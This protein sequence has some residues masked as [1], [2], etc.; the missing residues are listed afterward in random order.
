LT[1]SLALLIALAAHPSPS[2]PLPGG[3]ASPGDGPAATASGSPVSSPA[4]RLAEILA[5]GDEAAIPELLSLVRT[6]DE[7]FQ[8]NVVMGLVQHFPRQ[9]LGVLEALSQDGDAGVRASAAHGLGHVT[10]GD[11]VPALVRALR[12]PERRV[13]RGA[14]YSLTRPA[15]EGSLSALKIAGGAE[16]SPGPETMS[17]LARNRSAVLAEVLSATPPPGEEA[18]RAIADLADE[19]AA[20]ALVGHFARNLPAAERRLGA[21]LPRLQAANRVWLGR[22]V[23]PPLREATLTLVVDNVFTGAARSRPL[24]L[25][26]VAMQLARRRGEHLERGSALPLPLDGL[27]VVPQ[28]GSPRAESAKS[29][30]TLLRYRPLSPSY[31]IGFGTLSTFAWLSKLRPSEAVVTIEDRRAI[32]LREDLLDASGER[33]ARVTYSDWTRAGRDAWVPLRLSIDVAASEIADAT[34]HLRY[35]LEFQ[36]VQG[37]WVLEQGSVVELEGAGETLRARIRVADLSVTPL[38]PSR[39]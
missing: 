12:D 8:K 5:A 38:E 13:R 1:P 14:L 2:T 3:V 35:D 33:I 23:D 21:L 4:E 36:L 28:A 37:L 30:Q 31:D 27:V 7:V 17:A 25:T 34:R 15:V 18:W 11:V 32:P 6:D 26:P 39:R 24:R 19:P 29:G 20:R 10:V 22:P 16:F 9:A